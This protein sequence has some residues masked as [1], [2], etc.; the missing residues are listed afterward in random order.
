[1]LD[2]DIVV[3]I[4]MFHFVQFPISGARGNICVRNLLSSSAPKRSYEG[5]NSYDYCNEMY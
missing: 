4:A 5:D 3:I 1:M 2:P